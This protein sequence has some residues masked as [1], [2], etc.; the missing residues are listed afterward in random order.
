MQ[1]FTQAPENQSADAVTLAQA[2]VWFETLYLPSQSL[3]ES[4]RAEYRADV[5]QFVRYIEARGGKQPVEITLAQVEAFLARYEHRPSARRKAFALKAFFEFLSQ[6]E[7]ISH[8]LAEAQLEKI[9]DVSH[10]SLGIIMS[11]RTGF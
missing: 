9:E 3:E 6:A 11:F 4:S 7:W 8:N 2:E 1:D 10:T 5:A